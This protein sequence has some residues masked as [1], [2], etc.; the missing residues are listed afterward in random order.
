[1]SRLRVDL[2][3]LDDL[4]V[5][6]RQVRDELGRV[7]AELDAQVAGLHVTWTGGAAAAQALAHHRWS[8]GAAEV[9]EALAALHAVAATAHENYASAVATNRRMWS[10]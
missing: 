10:L 4:V 5:N 7:R 2:T 3:Q 8:R 9:Q 1:M 6:M